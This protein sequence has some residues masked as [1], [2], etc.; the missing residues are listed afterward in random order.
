MAKNF[1]PTLKPGGTITKKFHL[2]LQ[3]QCIKE[4]F[5]YLNLYKYVSNPEGG[6]KNIYQQDSVHLNNLV[7][8]ITLQLLERK[9]LYNKKYA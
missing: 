8:P 3:S 4:G 6:I 2:K 5:V 9:K 1:L 7:V